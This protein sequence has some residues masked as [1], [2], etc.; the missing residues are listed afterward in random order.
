M[1]CV[2]EALQWQR[3]AVDWFR[4]AALELSAWG[5]R[6]PDPGD[7]LQ[8][9]RSALEVGTDIPRPTA[10]SI[11]MRMLCAFLDRAAGG[12]FLGAWTRSANQLR[13]EMNP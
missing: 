4:K 12:R 7:G 8:S 3:P 2:S 9:D 13:S 10:R 1:P 6:E 11:A 5:N